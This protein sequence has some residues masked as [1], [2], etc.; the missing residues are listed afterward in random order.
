MK[1]EEGD[2]IVNTRK[3]NKSWPKDA[4]LVHVDR[5]PCS[6]ECMQQHPDN[7]DQPFCLNKEDSVKTYN[8]EKCT[9]AM[10]NTETNDK[11][12]NNN[13]AKTPMDAPSPE[14]ATT[15][16]LTGVANKDTQQTTLQVVPVNDKSKNNNE[17][18]SPTDAQSPEKDNQQMTSQAVPVD[19]EHTGVTS[20]KTNKVSIEQD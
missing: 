8:K 12:K 15:S 2:T 14:N 3:K 20:P 5:T 16:E 18:K 7:N 11:L 13:E 17:V 4:R 9:T 1:E 19:S 6:T 10:Q